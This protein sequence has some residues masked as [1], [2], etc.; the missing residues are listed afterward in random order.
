MIEG[1]LGQAYQMGQ[2]SERTS[3]EQIKK[4]MAECHADETDMWIKDGFEQ[5]LE[6]AL[7]IVATESVWADSKSA[8]T[9]DAIVSQSR[10]LG[11]VL[12]KAAAATTKWN[13][14]THHIHV[15]AR[16]IPPSPPRS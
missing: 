7:E 11:W 9:K 2:E 4:H 14:P 5:G 6:R 10:S 13:T 8:K 3:C 16:I 15:R 12:S 1:I